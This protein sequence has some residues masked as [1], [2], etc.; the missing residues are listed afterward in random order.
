MSDK[1]ERCPTC[2]GCAEHRILRPHPPPRPVWECDEEGRKRMAICSGRCTWLDACGRRGHCVYPRN[3]Q[4]PSSCA[5]CGHCV[6]GQMLGPE[7][8]D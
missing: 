8:C 5:D 3:M 1:P 7:G 6:P 4:W 2:G